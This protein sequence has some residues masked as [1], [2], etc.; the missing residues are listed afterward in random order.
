MYPV[1]SLRRSQSVSQLR[2]KHTESTDPGRIQSQ[3]DHA[4]AAF[5]PYSHRAPASPPPPDYVND[6]MVGTP[7]DASKTKPSAPVTIG[8]VAIDGDAVPPLPAR[9]NQTTGPIG[10]TPRNNRTPTR[11]AFTPIPTPRPDTPPVPNREPVIRRP[12]SDDPPP[13]PS[14]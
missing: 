1:P 10:P 7:L 9:V 14:R 8:E 6:P 4:L 11:F 12:S 2:N 3:L 13:L 5:R